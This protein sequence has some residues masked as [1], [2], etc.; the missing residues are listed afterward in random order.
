MP[1]LLRQEEAVLTVLQLITLL[2]VAL[3]LACSVAGKRRTLRAML[4]PIA[5]M[6]LATA[7]ALR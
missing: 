2:L 7:I 3:A 1:T 6:L 4:A 5:L